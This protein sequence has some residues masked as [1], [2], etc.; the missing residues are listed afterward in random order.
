M[1]NKKKYTQHTI[2]INPPDDT[3]E[4]IY[5]HMKTVTKNMHNIL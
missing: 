1:K 3:K 5:T 4:N 2:Y